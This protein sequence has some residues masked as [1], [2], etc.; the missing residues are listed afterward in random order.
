MNMSAPTPLPPP[1][2]L[3]DFA[4]V[5]RGLDDAMSEAVVAAVG[6]A[7]ED[8]RVYWGKV[9]IGVVRCVNGGLG[10]GVFLFVFT[11]GR[12]NAR[13]PCVCEAD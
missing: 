11:H 9:A 8:G 13:R 12:T 7:G 4:A 1:I 3:G 6:G 10:K 5:K 2:N